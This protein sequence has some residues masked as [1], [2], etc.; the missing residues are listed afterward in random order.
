[1]KVVFYESYTYK[2][3]VVSKDISVFEPGCVLQR[4]RGIIA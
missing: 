3:V 2:I 4:I 1:M